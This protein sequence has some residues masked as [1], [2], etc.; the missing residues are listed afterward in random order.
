[1]DA[2]IFAEGNV[3][4][5]LKQ[6]MKQ[7]GQDL[8][9]LKAIPLTASPSSITEDLRVNLSSASTIAG[10]ANNQYCMGP[11]QGMGLIQ[12]LAAGLASHT[13][14]SYPVSAAIFAP[15][16]VRWYTEAAENADEKRSEK[17]GFRE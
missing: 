9:K 4:D 3:T 7:L 11:Q 10:M 14:L 6:T 17:V 12:P 2:F 16:V 15:H 5:E 1:L 8:S 13:S